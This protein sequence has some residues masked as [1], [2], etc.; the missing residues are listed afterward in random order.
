MGKSRFR[1][2]ELSNP[3]FE[4]DGLRFITVKSENLKGRGDICVFVP[5]GDH[6]ELPLVTLLHGVYGSAW[7]WAFKGAAHL[8]T[9]RLIKEGKIKPMVLAMPS[10]GL[11]GDGSAYN[12]HDGR[13]FEKWVAEDVP[14]AIRENIDAVTDRS[15]LFLSG[16]SMG[17]FGAL[18][19]GAK[20]GE[21]YAGISAHSAITEISQME[22]FVEEPIS[23]Y[24]QAARFDEDAFTAILRNRSTL[25]PLRFDCGET[26][27]LIEHNR[28]LHAELE[29]AGIDHIY[30]EF[31]GGH[32]WP[33]WQVHLE[34][35]LLFFESILKKE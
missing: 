3:T 14:A 21:Q 16:L 30:Q 35:T 33:Y 15:Q 4:R 5:E 10:D 12:A 8:T 27:L 23:H 1:T 19:V 9:A 17:G 7:A 28:Q 24:R 32:E 13:D 11:W 20:Y 34:D 18:R 31:P 2:T 26:D 6:E 22:L 29:A 25:P